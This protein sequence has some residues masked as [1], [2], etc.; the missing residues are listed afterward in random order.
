MI[1]SVRKVAF[2]ATCKICEM[3]KCIVHFDKFCFNLLKFS[4]IRFMWEIE[5][6]WNLVRGMGGIW[7]IYSGKC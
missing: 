4:L 7:L 5:F 6:C 2:S 1:I 3:E